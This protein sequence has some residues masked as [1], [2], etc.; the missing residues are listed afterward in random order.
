MARLMG[1]AFAVARGS[2]LWIAWATPRK[3][4]ARARPDGLARRNSW[5]EA[6]LAWVSCGLIG[7]W[8]RAAL[9]VE[10]QVT[11]ACKAAEVEVRAQVEARVRASILSGGIQPATVELQCDDDVTETRVSGNGQNVL[12]RANRNALDIKDALLA[13]ADAALA[14]WVTLGTPVAAFTAP[15]SAPVPDSP[16]ALPPAPPVTARA[17]TRAS[18]GGPIKRSTDPG[19]LVARIA[20]G[21]RAEHWQPGSALGAQLGLEVQTSAVS[22]AAQGAYLVGLP[23]TARFSAGE[24][25]LGG[26][27]GWQ[28]AV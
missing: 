22:V 14:A 9:A 12:L 28:R 11:V 1:A 7:L 24:W 13:N 26:E 5:V 23:S 21:I 20:A 27:F 19:R 16:P 18:V 3:I 8:S 17:T 4:G 6:P 25:Q 15:V 10:A 2:L